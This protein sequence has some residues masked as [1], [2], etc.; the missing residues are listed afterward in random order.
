M[1]CASAER[2]LSGEQTHEVEQNTPEPRR[3]ERMEATTAPLEDPRSKMVRELG[4]EPCRL[5]RPA[6]RS[7]W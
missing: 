3:L 1:S 7:E 6:A 2:H 5:D 4:S